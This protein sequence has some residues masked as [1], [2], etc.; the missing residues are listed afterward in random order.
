M[1]TN[2]VLLESSASSLSTSPDNTQV[3]IAGSHS[4][5][6]I[7]Y[8]YAMNCYVDCLILFLFLV[9]KIYN[10][11]DGELIEK[12]NLYAAKSLNPFFSSSDVVW[13]PIEGMM[14]PCY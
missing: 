5:F 14:R 13:N 9:F 12:I 11:E 1:S 4:K 7:F 2:H 6:T 3:V 10:I 8:F